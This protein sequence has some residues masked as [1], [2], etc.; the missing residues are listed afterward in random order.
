MLS[1]ILIILLFLCLF[2][3]PKWLKYQASTYKDETGYTFW[4]TVSDKGTYG[5][6]VTYTYLEK[7]GGNR[8]ILANVYLKKKDGTTTEVDLIFI[9]E[10]GIYV[11]ESK[12]YSGWIFGDERRKNWTQT[13]PNKRKYPFF[14]PVWQNAAHLNAIQSTLEVE[15]H[16][17]HSYIV[18]SKRCTLKNIHVTT[19]RVEV[20]KRNELLKVLSTERQISAPVLTNFQINQYYYKLKAFTKADQATKVRHMQD[21]QRKISGR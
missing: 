8:K 1:F 9:C 11:V 16:L 2:V 5:E 4:Q 17:L 10:T 18:F 14:N 15:D 13:L 12:N 19:P 6:F 20:M 7:L 3:L 21:V